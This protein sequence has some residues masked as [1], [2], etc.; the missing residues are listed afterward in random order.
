MKKTLI[1]AAF[2]LLPLTSLAESRTDISPSTQD[3]L[4]KG[5]QALNPCTELVK[6]CF[7][8]G[9]EEFTNCLFTSGHHPFCGNTQL[10]SLVLKRWGF[11]PSS[12]GRENA[13]AFTGPQLI[14]RDC[15]KNFDGQLSGILTR[16]DVSAELLT[17]L[18][19]VLNS[20]NR[21]APVDLTRP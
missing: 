18:D 1:V 4:A 13:P 16:G 21:E 10:G 6:E 8:Y 19:G 15:V 3:V 2:F 14:D 20:C 17:N 5:H 9:G 11:T 12:T 7:A